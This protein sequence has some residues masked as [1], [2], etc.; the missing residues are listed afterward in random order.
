MLMSNSCL[1]H[2]SDTARENCQGYKG[3]YCTYHKD[4]QF[5]VPSHPRNRFWICRFPFETDT[6]KL[7]DPFLCHY[8]GAVLAR[9]HCF[10]CFSLGRN[11]KK[12]QRE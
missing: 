12:G 10:V 5:F 1:F 7:V 3:T 8:D 2:S 4:Q 6:I 11:L 9:D